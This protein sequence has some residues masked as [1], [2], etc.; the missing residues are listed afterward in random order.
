[1]FALNELTFILKVENFA[2]QK[3]PRVNYNLLHFNVSVRDLAWC[4][5]F[6]G[7][8]KK[9]DKTALFTP[10]NPNLLEDADPTYNLEPISLGVHYM[11]VEFLGKLSFGIYYTI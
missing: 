10:N 3:S 4:C 5:A 9:S 8:I 11:N 2:V 1:M 6:Y 7:Q